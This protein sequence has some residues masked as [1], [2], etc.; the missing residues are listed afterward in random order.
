MP[1]ISRTLTVKEV[2]A[3]TKPGQTSLG[4]VKGLCLYIDQRTGAKTYI[5]RY[6]LPG[7][8]RSI[9]SLGSYNAIT[10]KHARELA[11]QAR[12]LIEQG[13]NPLDARREELARQESL[14]QQQEMQ[15]LA[16]LHTLSYCADQFIS[17]RESSGY[18]RN[19]IRGESVT[20]SY[21]R[22]HINPLIG[23]IP[24][25]QLTANDVFTVLKPIWQSTTDTGR[26]CRSLVFHVYRWAKAK[27]WC[28]GDNPADTKGTLGVLLEPL[29]AG[30]KQRVN[31]NALD[32]KEVPRFV[33]ELLESK[34]ITYLL[35]AFSIV[36]ALRSKMARYARWSD[37]D[38]NAKTL[39]IPEENLKTKNRGAHTVFLSDAAI[40]ILKRLPRYKHVDLLFPSPRRMSYLSDASMSVVFKR[41]HA[42]RFSIDRIG[43]IDPVQTKKTG[44]PCIATQHGTARACFKTWASTGENRKIF[45]IEAVELCMAHKLHDDYDGAYNRATL[46]KERRDVMEKWGQYCF[47]E[48]EH[49]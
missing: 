26:N 33:R 43:W 25:S 22:N 32:Y 37:V 5:L 1:I 8:K 17:E 11:Q 48:I 29:A 27:G 28:D 24:I 30:K 14:R 38:L 18:W 4:G 20:R 36:T 2:S 41:M 23:N 35:T 34:D 46:E 44:S 39:T 3:I 19:N 21:F 12:Y 7:S 45:D 16:D 10:L 47:S 31:Y 13:I 15:R 9:M 6:Q 49:P 42:K 40:S